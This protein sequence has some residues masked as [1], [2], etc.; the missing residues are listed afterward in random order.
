M[1]SCLEDIFCN[2]D[3][4]SKEHKFRVFTESIC[5]SRRGDLL[6]LQKDMVSHLIKKRS[7]MKSFIQRRSLLYQS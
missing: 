3:E 1:T 7:D 6:I 5:L 2:L 4:D